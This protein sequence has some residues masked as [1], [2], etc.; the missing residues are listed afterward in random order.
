MALNGGGWT[1]QFTCRFTP[2]KDTRYL[3][4][5]RLG[6][7][8]GWFWR[9]RKISLTPEFDPRTDQPVASRIPTE[10]SPPTYEKRDIIFLLI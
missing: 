10:L 8:R 3:L 5:R 7:P 6:G 9:V 4:C 1:T 2:G